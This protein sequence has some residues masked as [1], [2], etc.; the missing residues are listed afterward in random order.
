[1]HLGKEVYTIFPPQHTACLEQWLDI[2]VCIPVILL[3][4]NTYIPFRIYVRSVD[5]RFRRCRRSFFVCCVCLPN[6]YR[7]RTQPHLLS[8]PGYRAALVRSGNAIRGAGWD[9]DGDAP[10]RARSA[11]DA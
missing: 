1:M 10:R 9:R 7:V 6:E 2:K 8:C 11:W 5:D 3:T 4:I